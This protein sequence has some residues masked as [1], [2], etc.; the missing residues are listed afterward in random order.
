MM[1]IVKYSD[2]LQYNDFSCVSQVFHLK[3]GNVKGL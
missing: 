1:D 2:S 3:L